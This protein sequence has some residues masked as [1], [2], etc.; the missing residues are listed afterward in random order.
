M[1]KCSIA[2]WSCIEQSLILA[3]AR[4]LAIIISLCDAKAHRIAMC[5]L[6]DAVIMQHAHRTWTVTSVMTNG[7]S[8]NVSHGRKLPADIPGR[9]VDRTPPDWCGRGVDFGPPFLTNLP[10]PDFRMVGTGLCPPVSSCTRCSRV[11]TVR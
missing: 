6:C 4:T 10:P 8:D 9:G 3:A 2:Y 11:T 1:Y 5:A 7:F